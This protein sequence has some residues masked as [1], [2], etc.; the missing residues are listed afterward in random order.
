[1]KRIVSG[2]CMILAILGTAACGRAGGPEGTAAVETEAAIQ[3]T[4]ETAVQ[5]QE[6]ESGETERSVLVAYFSCTGTTRGVA[7]QISSILGADLYEIVP[8]EAYTEED[9]DYGSEGSRTSLEQNDES[10]RPRISGTVENMEDYDVVFLGYPIWW[11][12]APHIMRTFVESC[13]LSGKTV[14]PFCTSGG[15][16]IGDSAKELAGLCT[17]NV[18]WEEGQRFSGSVSAE[19]LE[20]WIAELD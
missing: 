16:G 14:I 19:E 9:L 13:D 18:Q 4:K 3:E 10:S 6:T 5:E 15:S 12:K 2:L 1:M 20:R 8:E 7:E 17:G 11:G